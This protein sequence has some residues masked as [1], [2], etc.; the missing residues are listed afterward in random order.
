MAV[1]HMMGSIE[2]GVVTGVPPR[3]MSGV[4]TEPMVVGPI[5]TEV[6]IIILGRIQDLITITI[7]IAINIRIIIAIKGISVRTDHGEALRWWSTVGIAKAM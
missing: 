7:V 5:T 2:M 4:G 1:M 3:F 6:D